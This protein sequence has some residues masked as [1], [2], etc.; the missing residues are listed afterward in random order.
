MEVR[1]SSRTS[2]VIADFNIESVL[3]ALSQYQLDVCGPKS[4]PHVGQVSS[5]G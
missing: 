3:L 5:V 2:V 1:V 4:T